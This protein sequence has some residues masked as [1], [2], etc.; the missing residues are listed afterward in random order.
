MFSKY[1]ATKGVCFITNVFFKIYM[2]DILNILQV[3]LDPGI[4]L[5]TYIFLDILLKRCFREIKTD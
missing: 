2:D 5:N 1:W 3:L 4:K